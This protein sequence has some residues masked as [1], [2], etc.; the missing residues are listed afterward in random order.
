V[1]GFAPGIAIMELPFENSQDIRLSLSSISVG[2][3]IF[4]NRRTVAE[5]RV[6]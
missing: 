6:D 5:I 2:S 4:T 1:S 3:S